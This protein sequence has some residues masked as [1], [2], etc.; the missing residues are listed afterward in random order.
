MLALLLLLM[1]AGGG[2]SKPLPSLTLY[3]NFYISLQPTGGGWLWRVDQVGYATIPGEHQ[4]GPLTG[5]GEPRSYGEAMML[6]R[7]AVDGVLGG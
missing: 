4:L 3:R 7:A 2:D 5:D 1:L 6:A